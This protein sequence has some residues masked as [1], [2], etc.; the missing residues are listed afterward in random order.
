MHFK[1]KAG[2]LSVCALLSACGTIFNGSSQKVS[3]DSNVKNV[4]IYEN[5]NYLCTTPCTEKIAHGSDT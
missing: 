2:V 4:R 3:F 5:G 1:H